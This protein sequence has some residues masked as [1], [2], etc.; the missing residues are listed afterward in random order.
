VRPVQR[1]DHYGLVGQV[2][3]GQFR[4]DAPIGEGGCSV[5]YRGYHIG[6][7][8]LVAIKCL[9]LTHQLGSA[10]VETFERRF[11]DESKIQ[12]RLSQGSLHIVRTLA[13]GTTISSTTNALVPYMVL[14]W[15]EGFTLAEQLRARRERGETGRSLAEIV[16]MLDPVAEAMAFAH[17]LGVVHRDLNPSN[18]FAV[19][20]PNQ[21]LRL[22]VMDFGV[23]KVVSD[24]AMGMGPRAAT[25]GPIRMFTPAYGAPEQFSEAHG[26]VSP[27]TD[28][29]AFALL[30]V[31]MLTDRSPIEGEHLGEY[32]DRATDPL[33]RPTPWAMGVTSVGEAVE[34]LFV[35]ALGVDPAKRPSDLGAFW[36]ALKN[37]MGRDSEVAQRPSSP[38]PAPGASL[39]AKGTMIMLD[40]AAAA[41]IAAAEARMP[42]LSAKGRKGGTLQLAA[43]PG[44]PGE[45]A[46]SRP[47]SSFPASNGPSSFPP[48][49]ADS[50]SSSG[51]FPPMA[52]GH[53]VSVRPASSI[54]EPPVDS[55]GP[56]YGATEGKAGTSPLS[57]TVLPGQNLLS[58][59]L[60][61]I[62]DQKPPPILDSPTASSA[63]QSWHVGE[64]SLPARKA[65]LPGPAGVAASPS[66]PPAPPV[67]S[68]VGASEHGLTRAPLPAE[69]PTSG[70]SKALLA[71]LAL[72]AL[73]VVA[74]VTLAVFHFLPKAH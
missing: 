20:Q 42:P 55:L 9:K 31:E 54:H 29:Y 64:S 18:I 43:H 4:V 17:S 74:L 57:T 6:L 14:E 37:A 71:A 35:R 58:P 34:V 45:P 15:L 10:L 5:V 47:P 49:M 53:S 12:Y 19:V 13:A 61:A 28:V 44:I 2:L 68:L 21:P 1:V 26:Q 67:G 65:P 63:A 16:K 27:A 50:P 59:E 32:F 24:H 3:D 30:I 70:A 46:P 72:V 48:S 11:R 60:R 73:I 56:T 8:A 69:T 25:L 62:A 41:A 52:D 7:D 39:T 36:G 66:V 38:A 33:L 40:G 51:R 23:A 22:K